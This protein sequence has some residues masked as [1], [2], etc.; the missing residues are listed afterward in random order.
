MQTHNLATLVLFS[1][2]L[3]GG[4]SDARAGDPTAPL[5]TDLC[6]EPVLS[7]DGSPYIDSDGTTLSRFC[8]PRVD[9]PVLD[10]D[11]YC[12]IGT[13]ASCTL[14][15]TVGRCSAGMKFW[16]E[17]GLI[18]GSGKSATVECY[19]PGP[20][21]CSLGVCL[22]G[23]EYLGNGTVFEDSSWLCCTDDDCFYAGESGATPPADSYWPWNYT[24]CSWGAT[25]E[26]GTV[27]CL[28]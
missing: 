7:A 27:D 28:G 2:A 5:P 19:Q 3:L 15:S 26:D 22:P 11:V 20:S 1:V 18:T 12:S 17:Y 24:I 8:E 21:T 23:P 25:N 9:P 10:L 4:L 14:P 13:T 6:E 16:C